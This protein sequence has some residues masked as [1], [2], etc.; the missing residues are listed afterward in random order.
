MMNNALYSTSGLKLNIF[1]T[2]KITNK[3]KLKK[4]T[5]VKDVFHIL[6]VKKKK[7]AK[8]WLRLYQVSFLAT[9]VLNKLITRG[10]F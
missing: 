3:D 4:N 9:V 1:N 10:T 2:R 6:T 7:A 5:I 8:K